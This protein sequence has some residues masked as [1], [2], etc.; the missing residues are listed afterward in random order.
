MT[1][2]IIMK[3]RGE[4]NVWERNESFDSGGSLR[5]LNLRIR[6]DSFKLSYHCFS[7]TIIICLSSSVLSLPSSSPSPSSYDTLPQLWDLRN[8]MI[9]REG[10]PDYY[11]ENNNVRRRDRGTVRRMKN[12]SPGQRR[13]N[14]A[15]SVGQ[16]VGLASP[17]ISN[18]LSF[19]NWEPCCY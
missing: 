12:I 19:E 8:G 14:G 15:S 4:R 11:E 7:V 10:R 6:Q 5:K 3:E 1:G 9:R 13:G 2:R 16:G 18:W 17:L